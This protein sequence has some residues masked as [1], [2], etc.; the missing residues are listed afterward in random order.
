MRS[1]LTLFIVVALM[2]TGFAKSDKKKTDTAAG[3]NVVHF[4]ESTPNCK[5]AVQNGDRVDVV[6]N[7]QYE[8]AVTE[9][10]DTFAERYQNI[11]VRVKNLD[12]KALEVTPEAVKLQLL[13]PKAKTLKA[14]DPEKLSKDIERAAY[15]RKAD[16]VT[17]NCPVQQVTQCLPSASA[18]SEAENVVHEADGQKIWISEHALTAKTLQKNEKS[19]GSVFFPREKKMQDYAVLV[20]VGDTTYEFPGSTSTK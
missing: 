13:K 12:D 7:G 11:W 4:S 3:D 14:E 8:I 2:S 6:N 17:P 10:L 15:K 18:A 19:E 16:L 5:V 1:S 20:S 9:K